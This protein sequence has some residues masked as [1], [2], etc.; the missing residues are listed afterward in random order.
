MI[1]RRSQ[2]ALALDRGIQLARVV[3]KRRRLFAIER[4]AGR[5]DRTDCGDVVVRQQ[6][7]AGSHTHVAG[8][9]QGT[10][11]VAVIEPEKMADRFQNPLGFQVTSY[12]IN[13][14]ALENVK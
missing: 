13:P 9:H 10:A 8:R 12:R 7:V 2:R 6:L 5:I 1:A 3:R 4:G 11:H 14:D